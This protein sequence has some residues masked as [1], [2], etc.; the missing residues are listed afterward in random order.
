MANS[1]NLFIRELNK[2][3]TQLIHELISSGDTLSKP[4]ILDHFASFTSRHSCKAFLRVAYTRGFVGSD[5][6][7]HDR[8]CWEVHF[9]RAE[10]INEQTIDPLI[11]QIRRFVADFQ[12]HYDGWFTIK[13]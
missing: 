13:Q 6:F 5:S 9:S 7:N 12:G 10:V 3:T 11:E 8:D 1:Y 2:S 4:H